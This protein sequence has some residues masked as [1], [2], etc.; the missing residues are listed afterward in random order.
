MAS[1]LLSFVSSAPMY[2]W[3]FVAPRYTFS[4]KPILRLRSWM[5]SWLILFE[6]SAFHLGMVSAD[7]PN[8]INPHWNVWIIGIKSPHCLR[9]VF[10]HSE[11]S[12]LSTLRCRIVFPNKNDVFC[13][14]SLPSLRFPVIVLRGV[15]SG[16]ISQRHVM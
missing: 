9:A 6:L 10:C 4:I 5:F 8:G 12:K 3:I 7:L 16:P 14:V 2:T 15:Q 13:S 1:T 11:M